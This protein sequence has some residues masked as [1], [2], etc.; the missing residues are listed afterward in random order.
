MPVQNHVESRRRG[1][2]TT[3]DH[4]ES[5]ADGIEIVFRNPWAFFSCQMSRRVKERDRLRASKTR[6][7]LWASRHYLVALRSVHPPVQLAVG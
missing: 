4:Q 5:L 2:F 6:R 7:G 3:L 1:R